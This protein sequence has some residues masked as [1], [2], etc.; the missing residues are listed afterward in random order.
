M[1]QMSAD[2]PVCV[3]SVLDTEE[4]VN[5]DGACGRWF[6]RDCLKMAKSEYLRLS[7]NNKEK[8]LCSRSDCI[9]PSTLPENKILSQLQS[10]SQHISALSI[11]V[12]SLT[13]LPSK[14]DNLITEVNNLST[15]L[16]SLEVRV[17]A[18]EAKMKSLEEQLSTVNSSLTT[19][20]PE[21]TIAEMYDRARC[22]KNVMI[23]NLTESSNRNVNVRKEYDR[24]NVNKLLQAFL[25]QTDSDKVKI[26]RV[27]KPQ[28]SKIKPLKVIFENESDVSTFISN[29]SSGNAAQV[30]QSF[31]DIKVSRDRTPREGKY[32]KSLKLE[33]DQRASRGE[34]DLK[35]KYINNVPQI[36]KI[37]KN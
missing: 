22:A 31:S 35:I 28:P 27:G 4:G 36:V 33:L 12:D 17:D 18:N 11:K 15:S 16:T 7:G 1:A 30:D 20:N 6:H 23:F 19:S 21:L 32:Y 13:P 5:C 3:K 24:G 26:F 14:I 29:F 9:D 10:L 2:C 25:P 34:K 37:Q 8:W